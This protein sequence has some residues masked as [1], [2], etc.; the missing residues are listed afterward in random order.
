MMPIYEYEPVDHDCVMCPNRVAAIQS[1]NDEPLQFC[2]DCGLNV[3]RVISKV[4]I[5]LRCE[6]TASAA[7]KRGFT[8][9]KKA[10]PGTWEKVD[11]PGVD[12][13]KGDP[14]D[15]KAV[16][17]ESKPGRVLDLDKTS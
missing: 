9:W 14:A 2:P 5:N 13:I 3:R 16:R 6:K 8:T 11:G 15:V 1:I 10:A 7:A 12:V 17:E 4:S